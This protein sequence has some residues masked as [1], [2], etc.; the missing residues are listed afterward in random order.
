ML[1]RWGMYRL[2]R[3]PIGALGIAATAVMAGAGIIGF[4]KGAE[5]RRKRKGESGIVVIPKPTNGGAADEGDEPEETPGEFTFVTPTAAE[6]AACGGATTETWV[7]ANGTRHSRCVIKPGE[8]DPP[9]S[10]DPPIPSNGDFNCPPGYFYDALHKKCC[11]D[12][13]YWNVAS[14][15]CRPMGS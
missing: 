12:G 8:G 7:D 9:E 5:V 1:V 13:F 6:V 14:Q 10:D 3:N 2:Q 11:P 15:T 4:A